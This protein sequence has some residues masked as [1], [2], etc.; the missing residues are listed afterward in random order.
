ME[1][2]KLETNYKRNLFFYSTKIVPKDYKLNM[3]SNSINIYPDVCSDKFIGFGG[4]ITEAARI[5]IQFAL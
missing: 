2:V 1:V 5:C 4:A 3:E